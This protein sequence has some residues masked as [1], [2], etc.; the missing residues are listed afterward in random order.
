MNGRHLVYAA[1][2]NIRGGVT[3]YGENGVR[4]YF[5]KNV[6]RAV[7][8]YIAQAAMEEQIIEMKRRVCHG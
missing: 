7:K 1:E 4:R 8:A 5:C 3:V 6:N 2:K